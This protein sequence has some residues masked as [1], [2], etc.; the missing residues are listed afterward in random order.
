MPEQHKPEPWTLLAAHD[1]GEL[2]RVQCHYC[3]LTRHFLPRDLQTLLGN[4]TIEQLER[5]MRCERCGKTDY[6]SASLF[7][8]SATERNSLTVRRL[9]SVRLVRQISWRDEPP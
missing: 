9:A 7:L 3:R 2:I 1:R 8:P 6:L 4:V 5:R